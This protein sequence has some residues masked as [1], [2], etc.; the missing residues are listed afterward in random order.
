MATYDTILSNLQGALPTLNSSSLTAIY[1]KIVQVIAIAI[2]STLTEL[3]N[4]RT[5]IT[6]I[7]GN[8]RYG[9][10]GYYTE[11]ALA[12]QYTDDLI[13]DPVTLDY[14][15]ATVDTAK[16]IIAQAAF[17]VVPTG[18]ANILT[19]KV[20]KIDTDTNILAPLSNLE[21]A[22]FDTYFLNYEIPGLPVTKV[23]LPANVLNFNAVVTY[24]TTF[25]LT[26]LIE[27]VTAALL[28]FRDSFRFNGVLFTNDIET[29]VANNV[30]GVR[31]MAISGTTIDSVSFSGST[32]LQAGYFNYATGIELTI[33]YNPFNG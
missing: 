18:G 16:Q 33:T 8:Q 26:T 20:A 17:L 21:K 3:N 27:N 5:I 28:A 29:Y 30:A 23:S 1:K 22:A 10:S 32:Q 11:K 7:I 14:V 4:T 6:N 25:D 15:Y 31:N 2:D 9:R 12:F 19:L 13:V 24:Q